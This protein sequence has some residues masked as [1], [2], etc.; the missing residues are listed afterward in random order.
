MP[1]STQRQEFVLSAAHVTASPWPAQASGTAVDDPPGVGGAT[2]ADPLR[3][4][5]LPAPQAQ[6]QG[7]QV[8]PG[9]HAGQAQ[10]QVPPP[11][12]PQAPPP[13]L[14]RHAQG[15]QASPGAQTG[16]VQVHVPPPPPAGVFEQSHS[17]AG[18][19]AFAGHAIGCT[20]VQPP[21][22]ASRARQ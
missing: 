20:Q 18:Q 6:S 15:G 22:V 12:P 14:Q 21:P 8:A 7:G 16:Q 10:V 17:T 1:S 19:S 2:S 11:P 5:T 13:P 4:P 3:T 9:T